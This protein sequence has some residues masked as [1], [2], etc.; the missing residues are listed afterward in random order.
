MC[1]L[2]RQERS[3]KSV[4][5]SHDGGKLASGYGDDS[6]SIW[7]LSTNER[8]LGPLPGHTN[9]VFSLAFSPDDTR[10]A[11][12]SADETVKL[13]DPFTGDVV[14]TLQQGSR[15]YSVAFS[16]DGQTL[17]AGCSGDAVGLWRAATV[18]DVHAIGFR[19]I[20]G[21]HADS[22]LNSVSTRAASCR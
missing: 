17:V 18:D 4:A 6:I 10:L 7:H 21:F 13:W 22:S 19:H 5:F 14:L 3:I 2:D 16:P 9:V 11:S 15:V 1:K 12:G 20:V 8:L